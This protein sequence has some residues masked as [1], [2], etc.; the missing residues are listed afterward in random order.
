M[1][2]HCTKYTN[3]A[4]II[5]LYTAL[6]VFMSL[7]RAAGKNINLETFILPGTDVVHAIYSHLVD[8]W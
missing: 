7:E 2:G 3:I 8:V 6:T 4:N 1:P 5:C